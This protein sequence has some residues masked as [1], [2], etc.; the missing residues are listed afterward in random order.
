MM[1]AAA[2]EGQCWQMVGYAALHPPYAYCPNPDF[3]FASEPE[4]SPESGEAEILAIL[5]S[6]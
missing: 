6:L 4:D 5:S 2:K 3:S 1:M